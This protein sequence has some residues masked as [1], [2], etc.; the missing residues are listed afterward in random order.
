MLIWFNMKQLFSYSL[1]CGYLFV[2]QLLPAQTP[3]ELYHN[4]PVIEGWTL[5]PDKEVFHRDNLY[6]RINGA[7]PL[8]LENNFQEMTA[9]EYTRD[10]NYITIQAYRHAT[11]EDA[12]GMY[13]SERSSDMTFY[14]GIGGEA[15]GDGDGLFFFA[16]AVYVKMMANNETEEIR[17]AMLEIAQGFSVKIEADAAYPKLFAAFPQ[18]GLIPHTQAYISKNYIGHEFLKPAYT[19][20]Y[21]YQGRK[22]QLFIIDAQT[23]EN[24]SR[25]LLEYFSFTKQKSDGLSEGKLLIKDRYNGNIPVIWKGRYIIGALDEEG[26]DFQ[27]EIYLVFQEIF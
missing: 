3:E 25:I 16:G 23:A 26:A 9:T 2:S 7:A 1:F 5:S 11:P 17:Q 4:L 6:E 20:D 10:G 24:A 14:D 21:N 19:A 22:I 8:Y 13:S 18:E 12:F 27:E 15:Q